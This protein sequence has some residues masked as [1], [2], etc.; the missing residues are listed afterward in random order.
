MA[1]YPSVEDDTVLYG[2]ENVFADQN[3]KITLLDG[4]TL[5]VWGQVFFNGLPVGSVGTI[6][7]ASQ[8]EAEAG[9]NNTNAMTPLRT[10][11]AIDVQVDPV[12]NGH[13]SAGTGA[14]AA[15]AV[16]ATPNAAPMTGVNVQ[17]QLGQAA[18]QIATNTAAIGTGST[19]LSTHISNPTGAHA[20]TAVSAVAGAAPLTGAT[21]QAQLD[22]ARTGINGQSSLITAVDTNLSAHLNDTV[23]AHDASAISTAPNA[24]STGRNRCSGSARTSS[25]SSRYNS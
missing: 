2:K 15:T 18:T 8:A 10:S 9:V 24:S 11:Q 3:I 22:Q 6:P 7:I 20:A 21:V 5:E 23:D 25:Y 17:A 16:S 13:I 1:Q 19:N 12:L 14:H 4:S